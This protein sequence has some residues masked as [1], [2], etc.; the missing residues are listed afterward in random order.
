MFIHLRGSIF[1]FFSEMKHCTDLHLTMKK[2][3]SFFRSCE[4]A[5][6]GKLPSTGPLLPSYVCQY[7]FLFFENTAKI[8][9][10]PFTSPLLASVIITLTCIPQRKKSEKRLLGKHAA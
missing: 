8:I 10:A 2:E 5:T 1:Q 6:G 9:H 4:I 3:P 7:E